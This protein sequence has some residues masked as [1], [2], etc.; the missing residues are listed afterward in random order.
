MGI[1][2]D[3]IIVVVA[4][5]VGGLVA[6]RLRQ[7]VILGY[8]L[9]GIAVGPHTGGITVSSTTDI[10]HLAEIGV[11]LLLFGLGLEFSLKKLAPVRKVALLGAPLQMLL[12]IGFGFGF[13]R[14]LGFDS[15]SSL[16]LGALVSLSSTM[17]LLKAL[18]SQGWLG[19]LSSRVML[20]MLIVQDLAVVPLMITLPKLDEPGFGLSSLGIAALKAAAFLGAMFLLGTR[21]LPA[22]LKWVAR[23]GS[24]ELFVLAVTTVGLGV[25]YA[26]HA[27]GLS[28]AFGAFIAGMV[29]SESDYGHQ[30][31]S[32]IVPVRDLFGLLFFASVGML[33]DP[34]YLLE[35]ARLVATGVVVLSLGKAGIFAGV[36]RLF[37]Y[38]NV[39][40]LA[41]A[42]G[43]FQVGEFAF[44]LARVGVDDGSLSHDLYSFVL[45]VAIVTMALTPVMSGMTER[46]Y[47]RRRKSPGFQPLQNI[48]VAS[49]TLKDHVVIA[50]GGRHGRRIGEVLH[51]L[52][53]PY[54]VVEHDQRRFQGLKD[55]G[56]AAVFG[57]ATQE[58]VL[59]AAHAHDAKL[60]LVTTPDTQVTSAIVRQA[61]GLSSRLEIVAR[62]DDAKDVQELAGLELA[63][64]VQPELEAA[65]EM[66]RQ[67]LVR[68]GVA[69]EQIHEYADRVRRAQR[70]E[71]ASY[72]AYLGELA[73][74]TST[75]S[76]ALRWME[77]PPESPLVGTTLAS[78]DIRARTGASVV[79]V[80][81]SGDVML[82]PE[83]SFELSVG[84]DVGVVGTPAQQGAF[85]A[86][87]APPA[88]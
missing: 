87:L 25:G 59:E 18:M 52:G 47:A 9:A 34:R 11:A 63:E 51:H 19:T 1:A 83:A 65:L 32:D 75:T 57:D 10:E 14:L 88:E 67:G 45:T 13:G 36:T 50:G 28:F 27:V 82:N 71:S 74:T 26:T 31:L 15:L 80:R 7:P 40:P 39:V 58:S 54:V 70:G 72:V 79:A 77:V 68:T 6:H 33:L 85:A 35:H 2:T 41:T 62:A 66:M 12:T 29:L 55:Q 3:L 61:R 78:A 17:V 42:L 30:A 86:L 44:V 84:D 16:W 56:L 48:N 37:G 5:L 43:L 4:A 46:I 81:R 24:K 8:I 60:L 53:R 21:L 20:G 73:S 64:V 22:I 38:G 69:P 49:D 76:V 23:A